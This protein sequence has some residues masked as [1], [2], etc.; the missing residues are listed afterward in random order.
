MLTPATI[1]DIPFIQAIARKTWPP[2]F[3]NIL[4]ADQIAYML[5]QMYSTE[6]LLRQ[7]STPHIQYYLI[8]Q[9]AGFTA[10]E[11]H[12][13]Q[14]TNSKIQKL[15]ILPSHQGQGLGKSTIGM[16]GETSINHGDQA[17][18]LNVNKYN[19]AI[20]FYEKC[21]FVRWKSEIIDIG[22]GYVMDDYVYRLKL[23]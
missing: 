20:H 10:L 19:P 18:I 6:E 9:D 16:L 14:T 15:Y 1:T 13:D 2:T 22:Q 3:R 11:L 5:D 17:L 23:R 7:I 4:S 8:N 12:Y 21:G